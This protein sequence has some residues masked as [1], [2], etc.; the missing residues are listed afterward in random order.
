MSDTSDIGDKMDKPHL[1]DM[2][3]E[4]NKPVETGQLWTISV[5]LPQIGSFCSYKGKSYEIVSTQT[6]QEECTDVGYVRQ[7]LPKATFTTMCRLMPISDEGDDISGPD[8]PPITVPSDEL[9]GMI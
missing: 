8:N 6:F 2:S 9:D 1:T 7:M 3:G 5:K 4:W